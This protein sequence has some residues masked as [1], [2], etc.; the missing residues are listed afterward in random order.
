MRETDHTPS[1]PYKRPHVHVPTLKSMGSASL[2]APAASGHAARQ[3]SMHT[4][5]TTDGAQASRPSSVCSSCRMTH[6]SR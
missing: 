6:V 1:L 3:H 5:S 4:H 2:H